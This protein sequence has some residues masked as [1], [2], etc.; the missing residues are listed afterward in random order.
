MVQLTGRG[1]LNKLV[2]TMGR[3]LES[4]EGGIVCAIVFE[5]FAVVTG[6]SNFAPDTGLGEATVVAVG[7]RL[8]TVKNSKGVASVE[9]VLGLEGASNEIGENKSF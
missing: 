2:P 1:L 5:T 3:K 7:A 6:F 4:I 9:D 8:F